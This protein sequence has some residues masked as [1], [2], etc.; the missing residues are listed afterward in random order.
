M[1]KIRTAN[2]ILRERGFFGLGSAVIIYIYKRLTKGEQQPDYL[3]TIIFK[4]YVVWKMIQTLIQDKYLIIPAR[5][6]WVTYKIPEFEKIACVPSP[7]DSNH[8]TPQHKNQLSNAHQLEGFVELD[9][10]D[11][12]FDVG[13]YI[14]TFSI[15][16][17]EYAD[18]VI[19]IDPYASINSC[20]SENTTE[21]GNIEVLP[22]ACWNTTTTLELNLS[23]TPNE[24]SIVD[25]DKFDLGK[26]AKV[27]ADTISNIAKDRDIEKIDFLKL[28]GEGVEPEILEGAVGE[29]IIVEKMS[30]DCAAE[31]NGHAPTDEIVEILESNGYEYKI[32]KATPFYNG[33][34]V[35]AIN[36]NS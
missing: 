16:A 22:M 2:R 13:A 29:G 25:T 12:V 14:G 1:S 11:T 26:K 35:Y 24:N 32:K 34:I 28:E 15:L 4:I 23:K 7:L 6:N 17:A 21:Y 18:A 33:D 20:L 5:R 31:R 3:I 9:D 19:A 10:G 36:N 8:G 30:I 27:D